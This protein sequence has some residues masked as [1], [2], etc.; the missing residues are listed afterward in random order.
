MEATTNQFFADAAKRDSVIL[1]ILEGAQ[2]PLTQKDI[3]EKP[4]VR[5]LTTGIH[6]VNDSLKRLRDK[7]AKVPSNKHN[8]RFA[9]WPVEKLKTDKKHPHIKNHNKITVPKM[10]VIEP[11]VSTKDLHQELKLVRMF[12]QEQEYLT[13]LK[14]ALLMFKDYDKYRREIELEIQAIE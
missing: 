4:E 9:Y 5:A 3:Y 13:F 12:L 11:V 1:S 10:T 2:E 8:Y 6:N 7:V 14:G